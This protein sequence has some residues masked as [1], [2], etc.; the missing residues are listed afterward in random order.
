VYKAKNGTTGQ[1]D[2]NGTVYID[3]LKS[4]RD[5]LYS[6]GGGTIYVKAGTYDQTDDFVIDGSSTNREYIS[7]FYEPGTILNIAA[8]KKVLEL[9]NTVRYSKFVLPHLINVPSGHNVTILS[10][11]TTI[12]WKE[13]LFNDITM[14]N[15]VSSN[16]NGFSHI[17]ISVGGTGNSAMLMNVIRQEMGRCWYGDRGIIIENP[18]GW[19]NSNTFE[20]FFFE[21]PDVGVEFIKG[22]WDIYNNYFENVGVQR[23]AGTTHGF[24][25]LD[26]KRNVFI[27]C[28]S[29][30]FTGA[31]ITANIK[32]TASN[33]LIIGGLMTYTNFE[34]L[35][36]STTIL[37]ANRKKVILYQTQ[38]GNWTNP[39]NIAVFDGL[40]VVVYNSTQG[41]SRLYIYTNNAWHYIALT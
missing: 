41:G 36:N 12:N 1:I 33:T 37:D 13:Q 19:F 8:G 6:V 24:K 29:W 2:F 34:D 14:R 7:V 18:G 25:D 30:D 20:N 28:K 15:V 22:E 21:R 9:L 16:Q 5:A 40:M 11:R 26:G 10:M 17:R 35:S 27:N 38:T 39:S 3:V 23:D 31:Q 32:S 4:C